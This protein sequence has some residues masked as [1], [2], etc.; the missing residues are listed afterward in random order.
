MERLMAYV[1]RRELNRIA[2]NIGE[3]AE[4]AS[5]QDIGA[6]AIIVSSLCIDLGI[7]VASVMAC[8]TGELHDELCDYS[9]RLDERP[10]EHT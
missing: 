10:R 8:T 6:T 5:Y 4:L 2:Q 3:L 1:T 7:Q 9:R